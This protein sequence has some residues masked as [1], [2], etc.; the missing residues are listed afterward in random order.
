[1]FRMARVLGTGGAARA[2][3]AALADQGFTIVLAGRDPAKAQRAAR[4]A[5]SRRRASRGRSRALCR[6]HRLRLRRPR[7]V[8]RPGGQRQPAGH[9]RPAAAGVR[10]EPC[11]ARAASSTTSSPRRS[12]PPF[13]AAA[14]AAGHRTI[15]GLA[16]LIGQAALAFEKFFGAPAPAR[17]RRRTARDA[18]RMSRPATRPFVLGLTGSIGMGKSAVAAMFEAAGVPVFDADAEVRRLQGPGGLLLPAIEAAFPGIDRPR[19]RRCARSWA[20]WCSAIRAA[21][22]RLEA[23]VH[24][25]VAACAPGLPVEHAGQ[26]LVVFDIPLLFEKGGADAVDAVVV[27]SAP[28]A[29]QRARVL[30]RPGMTPEKFA[31]ILSLQMPDAEK[32]A[33]ADACDRHRHHARGNRSGGESAHRPAHPPLTRGPWAAGK[34]RA[35]PLASFIERVDTT[36]IH[37]R[38]RVRYRNHR[39]RPQDGRSDGR[40]RLHRAGQPGAHGRDLPRLFQSRPRHARRRP[41]RSTG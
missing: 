19:R 29:V 24:P 4:R 39:P 12:T 20:R 23:I 1:M 22:A 41:R 27:V 38:N 26:P 35:P 40:D 28:A 7:R 31:Q 8:P 33:R 6:H 30:A 9:A 17:A 11:T 3:V 32:R 10:L 37:A 36:T 25:A 14:R 15:D 16:M 18:D 5:R 13:L 2:I 34:S 21:L